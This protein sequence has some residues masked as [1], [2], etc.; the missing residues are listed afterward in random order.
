MCIRDRSAATDGGGG[1]GGGDRGDGGACASGG[2]R[3]RAGSDGG[4]TA[5]QLVRA[6]IDWNRL[7]ALEAEAALRAATVA[8]LEAEA[9]ASDRHAHAE[10]LE[11]ADLQS[12]LT[13]AYAESIRAKLALHAA[14][15][16]V[17]P[18]AEGGAI[19]AR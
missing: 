11:R 2:A 1:G 6:N 13:R 7:H 12:D 15:P 9:A 3:E 19:S 4:D 18:G 17:Q 16:D 5:S 10:P 8:E 14:I